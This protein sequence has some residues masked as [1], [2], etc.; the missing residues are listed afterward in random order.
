MEKFKSVIGIIFVVIVVILLGV[1]IYQGV[2]TPTTEESFN[3]I[4]S[5]YDRDN[6]NR[7]KASVT[8]DSYCASC[9]KYMEG[10]HRICTF[11]GQY[12]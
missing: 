4:L 8:N 9:K 7:L 10:T 1:G 11:C 6:V 5:N 3:K 12:L 2:T